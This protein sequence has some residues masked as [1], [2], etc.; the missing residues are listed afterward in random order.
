MINTT[1]SAVGRTML[2]NLEIDLLPDR[3]STV[4]CSQNN[5]R[6]VRS[7]RACSQSGEREPGRT[8]SNG[9]G[10]TNRGDHPGSSRVIQRAN[11]CLAQIG[12]HRIEVSYLDESKAR[13]FQVDDHAS[14]H[15]EQLRNYIHPI[16][17]KA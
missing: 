14:G 7:R 12:K 9:A 1:F 13:V 6:F 3:V 10:A 5:A 11:S 16:R 8:V 17:I 2:Q 15:R 4:A